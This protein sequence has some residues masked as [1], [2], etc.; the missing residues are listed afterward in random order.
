MADQAIALHNVS[1]G[2]GNITALENINISIA[3]GSFTG[4]IG[5]NGGGKTTLLK[6]ILGLIEP[7]SGRIEVFGH[8]PRHN[9]GMIGYVPQATT[10]NHQFPITVR[11]V[12]SLGRLAGKATWFHRYKTMDQEI[13]DLC[14]RRLEV[15]ELADRQIGQ[16]SGGQ[17]QRVLIARALAVKPVLLLLDEPTS[18]LDARSSSKVYEL[19]QDLNREITIIM[20]THDTL[21]ISS[22]VGSIACINHELHY[23]GEPALDPDVIMRLYGC[24]VDLI[25]HGVPHRVLEE[26]GGRRDFDHN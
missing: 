11:Q 15:L 21:A 26:H 4:I 22:C 24:P 2:Y 25:A 9:R 8:S 14:L 19:L 6:L 12:V 20:V 16:L 3:E 23:H 10:I 1:A 17:L 18:G 5:P 13:V 7:W